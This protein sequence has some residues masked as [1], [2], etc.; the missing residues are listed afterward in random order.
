MQELLTS[1]K[2]KWPVVIGRFTSEVN[3]LRSNRAQ[4][5]LIDDVTVE[6]Y[7]TATPIQQI[8]TVTIPEPRQLLVEPWDKNIIKDVEAV[9]QK[10]DKGLSISSDGNA[11]RISLPPMTEETRK[12]TVQMLHKKTEEARVGIRHIREDLL[13]KLK[14]QKENGDIGEDDFF[15]G[16]KDVQEIVDGHNE[17]IKKIAQEKEQE[18]MTV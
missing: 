14:Q 9:L 6:V 12:Q 13:K 1:Y 8:A 11:I 7:G 17:T 18:I 4:T 10:N 3:T 16:Q 2:D 5:S 15:K